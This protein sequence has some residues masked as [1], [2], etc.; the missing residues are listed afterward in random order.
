MVGTGSAA[1]R[2]CYCF[3]SPPPPSRRGRAGK[4]CACGG[5]PC[6]GSRLLRRLALPARGAL[7][8]LGVPHPPGAVP[9]LALQ[10]QTPRGLRWLRAGPARPSAPRGSQAAKNPSPARRNH[11]VAAGRACAVKAKPCAALRVAQAPALTAATPLLAHFLPPGRKTG[12]GYGRA[13][14]VA[15]P[16]VAAWLPTPASPCALSRGRQQA[17]SQPCA[18]GRAGAKRLCPRRWL[19]LL[20][21]AWAPRRLPRSR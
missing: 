19:T 15:L 10:P 3:L 18:G 11:S 7:L 21:E 20:Q 4:R 5:S 8:R 13:A 1:L 16:L 14:P 17:P 9:V 2:P 6:S 12:W